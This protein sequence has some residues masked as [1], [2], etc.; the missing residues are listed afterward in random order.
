MNAEEAMA[1]SRSETACLHRH[2]RRW[3]RAVPDGDEFPWTTEQIRAV[4]HA[5]HDLAADMD[6]CNP[7]TVVED[8]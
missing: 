4:R 5:L 7:R 6:K 3:D 8:E 2:V 1:L